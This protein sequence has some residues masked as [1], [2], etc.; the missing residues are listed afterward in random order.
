L[1]LQVGNFTGPI[2]G[3]FAVHVVGYGGFLAANAAASLAGLGCCFVLTSTSVDR[4]GSA[5]RC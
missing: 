1:A 4:D 2:F 3:A 5:G